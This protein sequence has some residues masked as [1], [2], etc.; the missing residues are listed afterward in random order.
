MPIVRLWDEGANW[1]AVYA[2]WMRSDSH[3]WLW[4]LSA[5][6]PDYALHRVL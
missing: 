6:T 3:N 4:R 1:S 5:L 2:N